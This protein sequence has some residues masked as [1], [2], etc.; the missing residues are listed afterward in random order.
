MLDDSQSPRVVKFSPS[1]G[2][3]LAGYV[4]GFMILL[5]LVLL[6]IV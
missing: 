2:G 4:I 5:C 6:G 1:I 3:I